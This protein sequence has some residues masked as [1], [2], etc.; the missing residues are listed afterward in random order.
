MAS[1]CRLPQLTA[2]IELVSEISRQLNDR[3]NEAVAEITSTFEE[4]ERAL[5]QRKTAL[6]T[7]LENICSTKQK[8]SYFLHIRTNDAC[9]CAGALASLHIHC[10]MHKHAQAFCSHLV[11]HDLPPVSPFCQN[12]STCWLNGFDFSTLPPSSSSCSFV[13]L[14]FFSLSSTYLSAGPAGSAFISPPGEGTH[15]EQ[16][17]LYRAGSQPWECYR[18]GLAGCNL[19]KQANKQFTAHAGIRYQKCRSS[20]AGWELLQNCGIF[21]HVKYDTSNTIHMSLA[22]LGAA[23]SEAD[24][25]AGNSAGQTRLPRE[26]T[27]KCTPGLSGIDCCLFSFKLIVSL[28]TSSWKFCFVLNPFSF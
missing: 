23:G 25:W 16:L 26:T 13:T 17:Q 11:K 3:K 15:P 7:D 22:S 12:T 24:E 6:I 1:S 18:G 27:S 10:Q 20:V 21:S 28:I 9:I 2:A 4:L 5:H 14:F 19:Y 8:V